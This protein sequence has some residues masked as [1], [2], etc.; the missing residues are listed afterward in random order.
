MLNNSVQTLINN[1]LN[2]KKDSID[3]NNITEG[4]SDIIDSVVGVDV[5]S[6]TSYTLYDDKPN[7]HTEYIN[8][9]L[10]EGQQLH[11]VAFIENNMITKLDC[12][13]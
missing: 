2:K 10:E 13:F 7:T 6:K 1:E 3:I 8:L 11:I 12:Y 5:E 9:M 4:I